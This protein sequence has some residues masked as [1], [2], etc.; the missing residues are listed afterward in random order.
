[1]GR[2]LFRDAVTSDAR[3]KSKMLQGACRLVELDRTGES[4]ADSTLLKRAIKLF[5]D[6]K[7]YSHDFEPSLLETSESYFKN[8]A[9]K[10]AGNYIATYVD[11]CN[12]LIERE[13]TRCDLFGLDRDTKRKLLEM[14]ERALV[15]N[16][17]DVLLLEKDVLG[18]LRTNNQAGLEQLYMLLERQDLGSKL[19][20]A[21][22]TFIKEEGS[23]IV[24]D[25]ENEDDMI[26]NLLQFKQNLDKI[27]KRSFRQNET[28]S[29]TLREAFETFMNQSRKT[30]ANWGTDNSKVGEMVAK[31]VD[32]LLRGGIKAIQGRD[33]R[34]RGAD[35][36]L[37]DED[38]EINKQLDQVLDLFRF[39]HG[40]AVFEAFYKTDL[41]RRLLM[42]RSANDEAEKGMLSRL[43]TGET[44]LNLLF[45]DLEL[46]FRNAECGAAFTHNLESMFKDMDLA[47][48][49]M[50][51]YNALIRER[52]ERPPFDLSVSVLSAAA[53]PSYP[54]VP[55]RLPAEISQAQNKFADFYNSKYKGRKLQWKDSLGHCQL[56]ARFSKGD[57]EIVVSSF[58][59]IVLLLFNNT[60]KQVWT[61]AEIKAK[62]ELCKFFPGLA[63]L[64]ARVAN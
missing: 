15:T 57:K 64:C 55:V 3:L 45:T 8:W 36:V 9:D 4:S 21:F 24:F 49:E 52:R 11:Q 63:S 31:Y 35:G 27:A 58:Q 19:K 32:L 34:S 50:A 44:F 59:A 62:T 29:N 60:K 56:K 61:Y 14:L 39:V 46:T 13:T 1:M 22:A 48:D 23:S 38:S 28:L 40:K 6:I 42:G 20:P 12:K 37:I 47:R 10:Q 7:V 43:K 54:D 41:A 33:A 26:P 25:E 16:K 2:T 5:H 30:E 51:A 17:E 53:W 18:L